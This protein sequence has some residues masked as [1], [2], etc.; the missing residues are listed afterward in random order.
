MVFVYG[1]G[2]FI[3]LLFYLSIVSFHLTKRKEKWKWKWKWKFQ[4][5]ERER[6]KV[7]D[8]NSFSSWIPLD[9]LHFVN[10]F[11]RKVR[12]LIVVCSLGSLLE[13]CFFRWVG[14]WGFIFVRGFEFRF[15]S[16]TFFFVFFFSRFSVRSHHGCVVEI[17]C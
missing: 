5:P 4:V 16:S 2:G 12:Y 8:L 7:E 6:E 13:C 10:S 14:G 9:L 15:F 3:Y 11:H 1:I 17:V